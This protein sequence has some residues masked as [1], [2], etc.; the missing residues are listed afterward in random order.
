MK[1][2]FLIFVLLFSF[3]NFAGV[4]QNL[5]DDQSM[6]IVSFDKFYA[7]TYQ[8]FLDSEVSYISK[9]KFEKILKKGNRV[10]SNGNVSQLSREDFLLYTNIK[11]VEGILLESFQNDSYAGVTQDQFKLVNDI[12]NAIK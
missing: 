1:K 12:L 3:S 2:I 6:M 7:V 4:I 8:G 10:L 11:F 5:D 9:V